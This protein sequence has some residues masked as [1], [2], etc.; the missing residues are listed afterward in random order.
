MIAKGCARGHGARRV[1]LLVRR[2]S[3]NPGVVH[4]KE[5]FLCG[6]TKMLVRDVAIRVGFEIDFLVIK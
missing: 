4:A 5:T 6:G 2:N 1:Q 3:V